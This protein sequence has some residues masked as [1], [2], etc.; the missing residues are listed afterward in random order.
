[1]ATRTFDLSSYRDVDVKSV[2]FRSVNGNDTLDASARCVP[3]DGGKIDQNVFIL[4][5]RQQIVAQS[6]LSYVDANGKSVTC[7]GPCLESIGWSSR[8]RE[9][10]AE[11]F[12]H[13]NGVSEEERE[14]FRKSLTSTPGS[15]DVSAQ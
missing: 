1:M 4:L 15:S 9:F 7:S 10:L 3:P 12:D 8:T 13:M 2:T 14:N 11:I 6:I 5:M